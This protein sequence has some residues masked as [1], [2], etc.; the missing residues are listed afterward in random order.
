MARISTEDQ[1]SLVEADPVV[2]GL[3][4]MARMMVSLTARSL[5]QLDVS[6][7]LP[8]FRLLVVLATSGPRRAVDLATE[9]AVQ[10]STTTRMCD[11]L[12]RKRLVGR[13][14]RPDDRR[15]AWVLLTP[16]GRELVAEVMKR[17]RDNI[18]ELVAGVA[19]PEPK[20]FSAGLQAL[21]CA[22]GEP[23]E[24]EWQ[25]LWNAFGS[26]PAVLT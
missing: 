19:I 21:A 12:V 22:A 4:A 24:P 3:L 26:H 1:E 23:S 11:R 5:A 13:H 18:A 14:E 10:P 20:A 9:L 16:R 2:D 25:I 7:T 6:V 17:R 15:V 8:Q